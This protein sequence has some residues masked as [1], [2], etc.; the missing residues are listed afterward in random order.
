MGAKLSAAEIVNI[1][2][3][4][5]KEQEGKSPKQNRKLI[6]CKK[7][8][9]KGDQGQNDHSTAKHVFQP[10]VA[11]QSAGNPL[12]ALKG[13]QSDKQYEHK[14]SYTAFILL[15]LAEQKRKNNKQAAEHAGKNKQDDDVQKLRAAQMKAR[16]KR[17]ELVGG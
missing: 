7:D 13:N 14:F 17:G 15:V 16:R 8:V 9:P 12:R 3:D 1:I 6:V 2:V 4:R 5:G 11:D 10:H